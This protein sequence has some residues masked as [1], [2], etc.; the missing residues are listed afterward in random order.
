MVMLVIKPDQSYQTI[1]HISVRKILDCVRVHLHT[2]LKLRRLFSLQS[3][4]SRKYI[5]ELKFWLRFE[6]VYSGAPFFPQAFVVQGKS[7][8]YEVKNVLDIHAK[9]KKKK[10]KA[11]EAPG[12]SEQIGGAVQPSPA[13]CI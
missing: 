6:R 10:K 1:A 5:N 9:C 2:K 7:I 11:G 3:S 8:K 13:H 4:H 12:C